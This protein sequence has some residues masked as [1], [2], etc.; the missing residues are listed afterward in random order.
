MA[1]QGWRPGLDYFGPSGLFSENAL[2]KPL[3]SYE[4]PKKL[5]KRREICHHYARRKRAA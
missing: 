5:A 4:Q 1:T 3:E 2:A